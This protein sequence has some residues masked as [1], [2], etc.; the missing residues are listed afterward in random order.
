MNERIDDIRRLSKARQEAL[1]KLSAERRAQ[2]L[3]SP[4]IIGSERRL[5]RERPIQ[6]VSPEKVAAQRNGQPRAVKASARPYL[7]IIFWNAN[8]YGQ[9]LYQSIRHQSSYILP[10]GTLFRLGLF[11]INFKEN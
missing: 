5:S 4:T 6:V 7:A 1:R 2:Q 11:F 9:I 8:K 10:N 3:G